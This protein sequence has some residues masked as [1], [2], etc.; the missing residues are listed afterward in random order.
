V[1]KY[2]Q[3]VGP[4][5]GYDEEAVRNFLSF[6]IDEKLEAPKSMQ[7]FEKFVNKKF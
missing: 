4:T 3:I 2:G 6:R 5:A 1:A 7:E